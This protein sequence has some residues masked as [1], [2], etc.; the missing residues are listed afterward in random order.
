LVFGGTDTTLDVIIDAKKLARYNVTIQQIMVAVRQS[1]QNISAG[2]LGMAKKNYRVRTISQFQNPLD[3]LEVV[4]F[5][6][7]IKRVYLRDVARVKKGYKKESTAVLHKGIQ[8]IVVGVR[9]EKGA[10]V[11]NMTD[12]VEKAVRNLNENVLLTQKLTLEMVYDQRPYIETATNLVKRNILVGSLLAICVLLGFLRSVRATLITG[13]AIPISAIGCFIF[14]WLLGR[15]LNIVSMA[16]ISFAVGM[17]VDNAIVVLENI[18][19][20][21][22]LGKTAFD[23]AYEGTKEVWGAVMA[24][25]ATTMAVFLPIIFIQEEAGQ[26]FRDIAIAIT[27]SIF[28][29]LIVSVSVIPT[30]YHLLYRKK[31]GGGADTKASKN[32]LQKSIVGPFLVGMIMKFSNLCMKNILTRLSTVLLFTS[33][34]IGVIFW[35]LPSAEYLPQGNRNLILNILIP[36]PGYSVEKLKSLGEYVYK[37]SEPYFQ[38]DNN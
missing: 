28:L 34:S 23:A 14:L 4:I 11:L 21:K 8:V 37:E 15:N 25:T 35:L 9:K 27:S 7:G 32:G 18:D 3:A 2:I 12:S 19:R 36:P 16:G 33:L 38:E 26:L 20:H 5:D 13:I 10:N 24:S 1:N 17:L 6:D 29:S 22:K 31:N 30:L